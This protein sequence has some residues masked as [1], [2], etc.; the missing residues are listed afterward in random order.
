MTFDRSIFI[1][2]FAQ[3]AKELIQKLNDGLIQLEK[4]P[5]NHNVIKEILRAVHTLK[6][7]SRVVRV[8]NV[9]QVSHK[10]EGL[11]I[12][13]QDG[14]RPLTG[15]IIDLLFQSTDLI[16]QCVE[17][18]LKGG[19]D[20]IDVTGL[21]HVLD[22][23]SN[24]EDISELLS[25]QY[26]PVGRKVASM[27][28]SGEKLTV[29]GAETLFENSLVFPQ[30]NIKKSPSPSIQLSV[31]DDSPLKPKVQET[32]R[33]G[34][35]KLDNA[36]RLVG[37]LA[38]S[39]KKSDRMLAV[40]K[41]LQRLSQRHAKRLRQMFQDTYTEFQK[42]MK[43]G[44]IDESLQLLKGIEKTFK[45][46]RDE[47]AMREIVIGE[48]YEDVLKMRMLPLSTVFETFPRAVRDMAKYFKKNI[49]LQITGEDTTLDKKIIE[50]L[51]GPLI[52]ILRNCIDH[53]IEHP[54][55]R[56]ALG[57]PATGLIT[58][59]AYHRSGH[60][61][62]E[63]HDDGRGIQQ[64]KLKQRAI[65]RELLSTET[66]RTL[67]ETELLNLVFLPRV[68]TS[69]LITDIS[70]RGV[71]M[72][73]VKTNIEQLKGFVSLSSRPGQGTSCML[74]LPVTLTTLRSLI[75]SSQNTRFAIPINSIEETLQIPAH[76][77]I[78]VV[79]HTAIR[80]RNQIIYVVNLA[81]VLGFAS[82]KNELQEQQFVLI[83]RADGKRIGLIVDGILD[84]QDVVVKQLPTHMQ[85]VKIIA[86]ATISSD[87]RIIL[88]LHIPEI[89]EFVKQATIKAREDPLA[90]ETEGG[91]PRILVVED[92]LSTGEIEKRIL[93][94]YGYQ[95][96]LAKD[97]VDALEQAEG[98]QYDLIVTDIEM[99]RMDGF[100]LT[101]ELR[102]MSNYAD[103]PIVIV[104]S[105]ERETDKK[106]GFH[107]GA[108]AYITKGDFEQRR[109]ID[110]VKS[111]V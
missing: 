13:V 51:N 98:V 69:D 40:L 52:H 101:E 46:S 33:V 96:D 75:I 60:I 94:S 95:V 6:G 31:S 76:K 32:I 72:D 50:K 61:K 99:P 1:G 89:V 18:I 41:E 3:E 93:E 100:T 85:H 87:N 82:K 44:L 14:Q 55:E 21:S 34:V 47:V 9:K 67:S 26:L 43:T 5:Q 70:G 68:S 73:I 37:E 84:E 74:T 77:F 88:I 20:T 66:A 65:Q 81:D 80:L 110:T 24:G 27:T 38:V 79:E 83:A 19:S 42:D 103:V 53:G 39:H 17:N 28:N 108:N 86:G 23:A 12:A 25:Q 59:N 57:K 8:T 4:D 91:S 48:L 54:E 63:I 29:N 111:L 22:C 11:L 97:G 36:V 58:I 109:L 15:D 35:D 107:V 7:T 102:N 71:G 45:E 2:K 10:M 92:S 106:R 56:K 64:E 78:Q 16:S 62:I 104:T 30:K 49:E 105:L 90:E